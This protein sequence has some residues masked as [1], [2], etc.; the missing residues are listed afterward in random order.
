MRQQPATDLPNTQQGITLIEV[1]IV[2]L[3]ISILTMMATMAVGNKIHKAR[4]ARCFADL[5]SVQ[6]TIYLDLS[7]DSSPPNPDTFWQNRWRGNKP[8]PYFYLIDN[9]DADSGHGNDL[10]GFDED[11]P[12]N[13]PRTG[14]DIDFVLVCQHDHADLAYYVYIIDEGP[15]TIA[16]ASNDPQLDQ[17]IPG[18]NGVCGSPGGSSGGGGPDK[19]KGKSGK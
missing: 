16:D 17:C 9:N 2:A 10:D 1:L 7:I 19:G 14:V 8:G 5:R 12:G 3:M 11:N 4:L 18:V 6:S 13:A 15:P